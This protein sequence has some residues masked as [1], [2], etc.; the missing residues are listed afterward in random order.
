MTSPLVATNVALARA[1]VRVLRDQIGGFADRVLRAAGLTAANVTAANGEQALRLLRSRPTELPKAVVAAAVVQAFAKLA[2]VSNVV[3]NIATLSERLDSQ[4]LSFRALDLM[5]ALT[6]V[7]A[8][9]DGALRRIEG[10]EAAVGMRGL[11]EISDWLRF[12]A[13]VALFSGLGVVAGAVL[14]VFAEMVDKI[15]GLGSEAAEAAQAACEAQAR[16]TGRRCT[17]E[18]YAAFFRD[19]RT[20]ERQDSLTNKMGDAAAGV[21]RAVGEA[22]GGALFWLLVIGGVG[23]A[24][25]FAAPALAERGA[26]SARRLRA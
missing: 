25:Y 23:A 2:A 6:R 13:V 22:V 8:Y 17:P 18:E 21:G 5:N 7:V 20:R 16:A 9:V 15:D 4:P 10:L 12:S 19:E 11:G 3:L 1:T 24:L 14:L 26:Q